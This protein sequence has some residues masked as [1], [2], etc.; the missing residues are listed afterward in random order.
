[1]YLWSQGL[2]HTLKS[3]NFTQMGMDLQDVAVHALTSPCSECTF[4]YNLFHIYSMYMECY[5]LPWN[6]ILREKIRMFYKLCL[7]CVLCVAM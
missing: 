1:M 6:G 3:W 2:T 7:V 5:I 4:S